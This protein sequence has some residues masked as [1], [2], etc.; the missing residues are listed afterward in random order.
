[1]DFMKGISRYFEL[2]REYQELHRGYIAR[3]V[4][5]TLNPNDND[6]A[7]GTPL[8]DYLGVGVDALRVIVAA[9]VGNFREPPRSI[10]DFPSGSGRVTRH[11]QAFF[12]EARIVAS[13]LYDRHLQF[14]VDELGIEGVLSRENLDEVDFGQCF[15]LIFCGSLLTHLPED[16]FRS[17]FRLMSRSLSD[18]GIAILTLHGRHS[19]Y[20]QEKKPHNWSYIEDELYVIVKS[21]ISAKGFGYVDYEW[22]TRSPLFDRHAHYGVSFSRPHWTLKMMEDDYKIRILSYVERG[23]HD[24]QD[25][26]VFGRPGINHQSRF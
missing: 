6:F 16:G 15:D 25:V 17:A 8:D 24:H 3:G 2:Q 26:L 5:T 7:P 10:L 9:L 22:L 18:T 14:C 20:I 11:L 4:K 19:E 21:M 23:W 13:D 1:M 12:P